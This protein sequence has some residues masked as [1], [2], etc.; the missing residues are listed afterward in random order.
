MIDLV[1]LAIGIIAGMGIAS[2][3]FVVAIAAGT[4][5]L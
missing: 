4:K 1:V 2:V 3:I 5:H